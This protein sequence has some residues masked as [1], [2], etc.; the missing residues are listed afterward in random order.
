MITRVRAAEGATFVPQES[1][2]SIDVAAVRDC[3][4]SPAETLRAT[5]S[6]APAATL[7]R[8]DPYLGYTARHLFGRRTT[9]VTSKPD[10]QFWGS[11]LAS[12]TTPDEMRLLAAKHAAN[13]ESVST[14]PEVHSVLESR[15]RWFID[16]MADC[17]RAGYFSPNALTAMQR[18]RQTR[19]IVGD[20]LSDQF[21]HNASGYWFG[22]DEVV[23]NQPL[24]LPLRHQRRALFDFLYSGTPLHELAHSGFSKRESPFPEPL[25]ETF[26]EDCVQLAFAL[27]DGRDPGDLYPQAHSAQD[28]RRSYIGRRK[29]RHT[30][31]T[32][33]RDTIDLKL[34]M[35][36]GSSEGANSRETMELHRAADAS[37]GIRNAMQ[38]IYRRLAQVE[39]WMS[40][41]GDNNGY[42][43]KN[44]AAMQVVDELLRRPEL[45]FGKGY[46]RPNERIGAVALAA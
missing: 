27:T 32:A 21:L 39:R 12:N 9:L 8:F 11:W 19:F 18:M 24:D 45:V 6:T 40:L 14:D 15:K 30:I 20:P 46:K 16:R 42:L 37:W 38:R 41:R 36:A 28:W 22:G 23:L 35:R 7:A 26:V 29:L 25:E 17:L 10:S 2:P 31:L 13:V 44:K 4:V 3:K 33:G 34:Y 1:P 5:L 43:I